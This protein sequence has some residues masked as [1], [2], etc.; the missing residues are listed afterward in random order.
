[1]DNIKFIPL[2]N[3]IIVEL[4]DITGRKYGNLYVP[5]TGKELVRVGNIIAIGDK[6]MQ[7]QVGDKIAFSSYSGVN[8]HMPKYGLI[9]DVRY[10]VLS[11]DE[12]LFKVEVL[13]EQAEQNG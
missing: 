10:R 4:E 6:V 5:D 12:V 1:M 7:F 3:R 11:E 8:I 13:K 9:D 2:G